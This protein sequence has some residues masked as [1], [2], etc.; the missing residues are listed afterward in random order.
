MKILFSFDLKDKYLES[1]KNSFDNIEVKKTEDTDLLSK[2]IK[3]TDVLVAMLMRK[4]DTDLIKMGNNLKWIQS[5]SAGVD[6]FLED[7]SFKYL[8][9]NEI[10]LTSVR[11]IHKDSM[12][13]QVMGYLISFSRRLPDL[14]ELQKKKEWDRLKVGYLKD[15]TLSIFGLGAVGQEV[16][17]KA[18]AFKMN[19]IGVKRNTDVEIPGVQKI[20]SPDQA[21]KVLNKSDYVVVT[22]PLTEKTRGFFDYDKFKAMQKS[23]Y[24]INVARGEIV[25]E[26]EM[27]KALN[28]DLIAGA[29]LDVFEEEPLPEKSPLY[30]MDNVI[31]TPHTS[32]LFP[33]YNKEAVEIFKNNLRLFLEGKELKNVIDPNRQY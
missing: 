31:L 25:E 14:M 28:K 1:I 5:W 18:Q 3:N 15:K 7:N 22:M 29:A 12:S 21:E 33:D 10:S 23:A 32:G 9:E 11:G 24:F 19:V 6:K 26:K 17:K 16:A 13:E 4:F 8:K 2:E 30:E 27:I 20:Y